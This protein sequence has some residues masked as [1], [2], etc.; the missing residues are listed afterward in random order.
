MRGKGGSWS[1]SPSRLLNSRRASDGHQNRETK[2]AQ[3]TPMVTAAERWKAISTTDP[4]SCLTLYLFFRRGVARTHLESAPHYH[5]R[6]AKLT[7]ENRHVRLYVRRTNR[8]VVA[9]C[10]LAMM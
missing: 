10:G 3:Q 9:Y 5:E 1:Y 8:P 4:L 7:H 2:P 6:G